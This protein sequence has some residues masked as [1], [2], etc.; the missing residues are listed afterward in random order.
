MLWE[1]EPS[2]GFAYVPYRQLTRVTLQRGHSISSWKTLL[3][4]HEPF[5]LN[6]FYASGVR[7]QCHQL[8]AVHRLMSWSVLCGNTQQFIRRQLDL[9]ILMWLAGGRQKEELALM[10]EP[11]LIRHMSIWKYLISILSHVSYYVFISWVI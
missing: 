10:L 6:C 11:P 1:T 5:F 3:C 2:G 8:P 9:C 7:E 4:C